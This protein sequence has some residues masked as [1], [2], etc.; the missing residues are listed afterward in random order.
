MGHLHAE[1]TDALVVRVSI[2][3]EKKKN[4]TEVKLTKFASEPLQQM[5]GSGRNNVN[6]QQRRPLFK[7]KRHKHWFVGHLWDP[8]YWYSPAAVSHYPGSVTE[9]IKA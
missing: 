8:R 5:S 1:N 9:S 3:I 2:Q 7:V 4:Y 6:K